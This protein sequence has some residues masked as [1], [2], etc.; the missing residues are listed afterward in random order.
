[1]KRLKIAFGLAVV[2]GLMAIVAA[3]AMAVPRWVHCVKSTTGKYSTGLCNAAGT[4]WETK[5]LV[6]TSEVTSSG[7]LELEDEKATGGAVAIKCSGENVGWVT[8]LENKNEPGQDGISAINNI[9]CVFV[10]HGSCEEGK[11]L[12]V[13]PTN[14][15]W[16][17]K[18]SEVGTEVRDD[19]LS[20]SKKPTGE[21]FPGWSVECVVGGILKIDDVCEHNDTTVNVIANR[22][23]GKT[24][25]VFDEISNEKGHRAR[26]TV[27]GEE[28]G[29]VRGTILGQLT[30]GNA[31]WILAPNLHT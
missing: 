21:G 4:G 29:F 19:L 3:P 10:K 2:A 8:N 12:K 5:E 18:L 17:T 31:L 24:E 6:N 20:G 26:C 9:K 15:P 30:S 14:L 13:I 28:S 7:S 23:T 1:M 25:F 22:T 11:T 16:G 27:S